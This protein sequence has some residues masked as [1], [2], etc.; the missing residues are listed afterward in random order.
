MRGLTPE[1]ELEGSASWHTIL[2][3]PFGRGGSGFSVLDVTNP[4]VKD[5]LGPLH[6]FTVYNDYINNNVFIMDHTGEIIRREYNSSSSSLSS[7]QEAERAQRNFNFAVDTD[8]GLDS[9]VTTQQDTIAVCQ[10]NSDATTNFRTDGTASCYIG[11]TFTF[12]NIFFDTPNNQSIDQNMINVSELVE[13]EFVPV[14]FTDARM[15]NGEFVITFPENKIHN[16]GSSVNETRSTNNIFIQTSCT[17]STGI[18]PNFDYSKLGETWSKPR[19]AK[20]P[21]DIEGERSDPANDKY[22][23]ITSFPIGT[24]SGEVSI[25]VIGPPF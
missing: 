25:I 7:S 5:G 14:A 10:S 15:V 1:G 2:F 11:N 19:I 21:S 17:A 4:I 23:A 9:D 8:G 13:G 18:D 22:V 24:P 16:A 6:M 12:D 3:Q 20:L